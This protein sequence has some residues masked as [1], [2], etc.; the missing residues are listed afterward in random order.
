MIR[1]PTNVIVM[2][3][4]CLLFSVTAFAQIN[5]PEINVYGAG[6]VYTT[7]HFVI[8]FPQALTP[9]PGQVK[10]DAVGRFGTRFGVYTRGHWSEEFFY[11]VESNGMKIS[12][13]GTA[14]KTT[15]VRLRIHN[16]GANALYYL[17]ETETHAIQPFL[18]AGLGGGF[19]QIRQESRAFLND[20]AGG[21]LRDM[22]NSNVLVFNYGFGIKTHSTGRFGVRMDIR[23]YLGPQPT[24][25]LATQ[26]T[27]P[28]ATVLPATGALHNGEF[29][30][31]LIFYF[32]KR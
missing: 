17:V 9:T 23:D 15:D 13:G 8:G 30:L 7:N 5:E 26:S 29:S 3:G 21:N 28:T 19:Y 22:D 18:S 32:W 6:S 1:R 25:G 4:A 12:Q 10:F 14:P 27:N 16:Y 2:V 11:N 20:P 24:F 31:G